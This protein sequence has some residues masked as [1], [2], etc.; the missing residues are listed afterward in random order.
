MTAIAP[1]PGLSPLHRR[2]S[3]TG[4]LLVLLLASP[5]PGATTEKAKPAPASAQPL[6]APEAKVL[7]GYAWREIGPYRGGRVTAVAG[8]AGQ[9]HVYYFG[10]T[11]GGVW[12]TDE[13][14]RELDARD[15]RPAGDRLG[16]RDRG[17]AVRPERHLRRHGRELHPRQR[18][19]RRR[20][21][22]LDRRRQD[23]DARRARATRG[24]S[25]AS[26]STRATP[27]SSTSRRSA[28]RS[29]PNA[30]RGVFRS[31]DGGKTWQK[32]L[33]V[34]DKT[35]AVDLAMDPRNPR[36][37]YAAIWQVQ[38]T[39]W[40]LD[41]RRPGQRRSTSRPTAATPGTKL[42]GKGLPKGPWGRIGVAVSP[43]RPER[44]Y[45][46]IEAEDGGVFRSDDAGATWQRDERRAQAAAARLVLHARLRRPE[47][48]RHR[49]RA[50]RPASSARPTAAGRSADPRAARRQPRPVD[51]PER[52]A[53]HDR[54]QRRRRHR[55]VRRRARR[56]TRADNQ[57]T[58]QFYHVIAD[59]QFPYR[60]YGAQQ[61]N[62]TVRDR[63]PQRRRRHRR[64][65]DWYDVGGGES[66]FIAPKP[67]DP[68]IVYAGCYGGYI[69]AL[70]PAHRPGARRHGLAR[71]PDGLGR[72]GHEVPLP[73]DLP[74]RVLAARP[75]R[76]LRRRQRAV[77]HDER[78]R[79]AGR[80][81]APT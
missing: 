24:R 7:E 39:P 11:G 45:A 13:R 51:R 33:F 19:A 42:D 28:T 62:C 81:S 10:A 57:P 15:R 79:R 67:G 16:R 41:E 30:E 35:G 56:W 65:T 50:Q 75:E 8:V 26:A 32:V 18:L 78:G 27:T 54:G 61:D 64:A 21:L 63:E 74:D 80:R 40:S 58:A 5:A 12:K 4:A 9:P 38:R 36:V 52:P 47:G 73:V 71:Q 49:L 6:A 69:A 17:G 1:R 76:A 22:P 2:R 37:L 29:G 77:P 72:R 20:R 53:A 70:R 43:A 55:H 25:A 14:R 68:D 60:V 23:L 34:D 46:V 48:P 44:V 31:R 59:D 3:A 66:G